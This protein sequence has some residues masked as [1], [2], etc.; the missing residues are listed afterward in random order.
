MV[1]PKLFLMATIGRC[2]LSFIAVRIVVVWSGCDPK[3]ILSASRLRLQ[4]SDRASHWNQ[5]VIDGYPALA[6]PARVIGF[7][8]W[9]K[10]SK[11]VWQIPGLKVSWPGLIIFCNQGRS[12]SADRFNLPPWAFFIHPTEQCHF[13][14]LFFGI[15]LQKPQKRRKKM[16]EDEKMQVAVFRFSVIG[17]FVTT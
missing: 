8:P 13:L 14:S 17:D 16:T 4:R 3:G 6:V 15:R 11:P 12:R 9:K 10:G 2:C 1:L 7:W 5:Q